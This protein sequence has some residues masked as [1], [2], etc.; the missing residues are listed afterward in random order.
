[1]LR[2]GRIDYANCTPIFHAFQAG[3]AAGD[4]L[5]ESGVPSVLNSRLAAGHIDVCP[6][7][8]FEYACHA[9]RYLILPGLSISSIGPVASVLLFSRLPIQRLDGA[10]IMLSTDSA[11]SVNLLKILLARRYGFSSHF[12]PCPP[13]SRIA[14]HAGSAA[15]LLIG[16]SALKAAMEPDSGYVYDLGGLWYEWTGLPFVFALWLCTR[17]AVERARREVCLLVEKLHKAKRDAALGLDA[18]A[19][20]SPDASW[21]GRERLLAYWR[22]NISYDLGEE[23]IAGLQLFYRHA[24]E[25]GLVDA[26]PEVHFLDMGP[27]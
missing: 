11:T 3:A 1:M 22:D 12:R 4:Y 13:G 18:I 2:I 26:A 24:A 15:M 6:S 27:H 5:F 21:M 20:S 17:P 19:D 7:S 16:D 25:M 8:S 10:E 23:H 14:S 9:E